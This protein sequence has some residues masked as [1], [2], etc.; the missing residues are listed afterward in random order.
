MI[1]KQD[2][3]LILKLLCRKLNF[4]IL[5]IKAIWF[6]YCATYTVSLLGHLWNFSQ[7]ASKKPSFL[8]NLNMKIGA[9]ISG[10][11]VAHNVHASLV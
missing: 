1:N 7:H 4:S 8:P 9:G 2:K 3:L 6:E 11:F 10:Y 5:C